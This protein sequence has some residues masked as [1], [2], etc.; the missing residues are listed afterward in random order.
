MGHST[1]IVALMVKG[2]AP[3]LPRREVSGTL[4][5]IIETLNGTHRSG[6]P[7]PVAAAVVD[8]APPPVNEDGTEWRIARPSVARRLCD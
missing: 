6:N 5:T 3:F 2:G 4:Q 7:E 1:T 8:A